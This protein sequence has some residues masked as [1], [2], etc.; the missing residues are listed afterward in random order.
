M[1]K[2]VI[3]LLALLT[4]LLAGCGTKELKSAVPS[5][6]QRI[7]GDYDELVTFRLNGYEAPALQGT[8]ILTGRMTAV[9]QISEGSAAAE[10]AFNPVAP[11]RKAL[12]AGALAVS[13]SDERLWSL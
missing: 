12:T 4:L 11:N 13:V 3:I 1:K 5:W 2:L 10:W 8:D 7:S 6:E 9:M